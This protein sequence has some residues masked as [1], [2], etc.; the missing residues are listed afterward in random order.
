MKAEKNQ[1]VVMG[2][3]VA[4]YGILGWL[5]IQPDTE[6]VD[7][8]LDYPVWWLGR[9]DNSNQPGIKNMPWR[10]FEVESARVHGET[11]LVKLKGIN[12]RDA[13]FAFKSK[14]VAVPRAELPEAEEGEYYWS[15]LI[16]LEVTN[17]QQ[18]KLGKVVD[19]FE[20]GANDVIVVQGDR[21]R[22]L[23]F[24]GQVILDVNLQAGTMQVDWDAEF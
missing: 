1:M 11:L 19:V 6:Y 8:L 2:R 14:H 3:I 16:G 15:D 20:T 24:V 12:D 13:A 7:S 18:V 9:D 10:E 21:E 17:L 5:K 4:P 23:P 22:L